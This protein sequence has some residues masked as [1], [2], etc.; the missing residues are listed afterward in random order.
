MSTS[1]D[2][3]RGF[4]G[5]RAEGIA[6]LVFTGCSW[7]LT[8][9]QS[10]FLLS[11]LPPFTMRATCG[12][13]GCALAFLLAVLRRES[14]VP[15]RG[16][17]GRLL[18][19]SMLNYGLFILL[20]AKALAWLSASQAVVLTYTLPIWASVFAWPMLGER[21]TPL[22]VFAIV[23]GLTGVTLL[24][25]LGSA[26]AG[27]HEL[28]GAALCLAA[29][30]LFGLGTVIAKRKPLAMPPITAVAWQALFGSMPVTLAALTETPD[31]AGMTPLGWS[32]VAYIAILPMTIAYLTWFRALR[33]VAA[34]TA[35][36]TVLLS[37]M[38]GVAGSALLLGET[39]GPRQVL[40]L[41]LTL[42]GVAL[43][44]RR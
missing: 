8:W 44:T 5:S 35:A 33:L 20:T 4:L 34:S 10:K 15:P 32:A 40:G 30:M 24:V 14:L 38:I 21:P 31:F 28:A 42:T 18:V 29:A 17:W 25:N 22:R 2:G 23:L 9:P 7:G 43:A 27:P 37:P 26:S 3:R 41:V 11:L 12:I 39:L 16:Q 6:L 1:V 36:T 13:A 19:F